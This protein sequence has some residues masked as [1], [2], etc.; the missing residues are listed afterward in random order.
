MRRLLML[1]MILGVSL[2]IAK[3]KVDD[4]WQTRTL[5]RILTKETNHIP[6]IEQE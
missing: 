4:D 5:V 1:L 6:E 2:G 3:K